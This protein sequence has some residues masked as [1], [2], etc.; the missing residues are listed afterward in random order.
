MWFDR[1]LCCL[2]KANWKIFLWE[3]F[4]P[5][6]WELDSRRKI[7]EVI[8]PIASG[9]TYV[10]EHF[11]VKIK[12]HRHLSSTKAFPDKACISILLVS[13]R[14]YLASDNV[15]LNLSVFAVWLLHILRIQAWITGIQLSNR[16]PVLAN[17]C[18]NLRFSQLASSQWALWAAQD[19]YGNLVYANYFQDLWTQGWQMF[20]IVKRTKETCISFS[21]NLILSSGINLIRYFDW[22]H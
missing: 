1:S 21:P 12:F 18:S 13:N 9:N 17:L 8:H 22:T 5:L 16:F 19:A 2:G 14:Y 6:Y 11:L 10:K 20:Y 3:V 7:P 15:T 4:L